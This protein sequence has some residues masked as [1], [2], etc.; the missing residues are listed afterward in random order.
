MA[1]FVKL[2]RI[3]ERM[4]CMTWFDPQYDYISEFIDNWNSKLGRFKGMLIVVA[5]L[6]LVA[7]VLCALLPEETFLTIQIFAA[8]ALIVQGIGHI[9][10]YAFTTYYFK[11]PMLIIAGI[12]DILLGLMVASMPVGVTVATLTF[13]FAF[14]LLFHGAEHIAFASRMK[15]YRI[16]NTGAITFSGVVSIILAVIFIL[17]PLLSMLMLNYILAAYLI[18]EGIAL[19]VEALSLKQIHG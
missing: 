2:C 8:A 18:V 10:S 12:L 5:V 17:L 1:G 9:V 14:L 16:M 4:V 13:L 3:E 15:Y 7:G 19:L 6:L 11:D